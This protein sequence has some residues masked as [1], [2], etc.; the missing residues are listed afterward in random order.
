GSERKPARIRLFDG[1]GPAAGD[2]D[3]AYGG[4]AA[5]DQFAAAQYRRADDSAAR[6]VEA[7][8]DKLGAAGCDGGTERGPPH[9]H[10]GPAEDCRTDTRPAS[11]DGCEDKTGDDSPDLNAE[12]ILL[13]V[14]A[15]ERHRDGGTAGLNLLKRPSKL[16]ARKNLSTYDRARENI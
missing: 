2:G 12:Y 9:L 1:K 3:R 6:P 10:D 16:I 4:A 8:L 14:L 11:L 7:I 13:D 15:L 5:D